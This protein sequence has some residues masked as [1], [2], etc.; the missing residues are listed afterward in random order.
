MSKIKNSLAG[1]AFV[2]LAIFLFAST[3]NAQSGT[4]KYVYTINYAMEGK[5]EFLNWVKTIVTTLQEPKELLSIAS[6]DNYFNISPARVVEFEFASNIDAAKYFDL[7]EIK[8]VV[9]QTIN[10]GIT[11]QTIVLNKR[12]DYNP[13][14]IKRRKIKYVHFLDY[15]VGNKAKYLNYVKSIV[16]TLQKPEEIKRIT[17][18]DNYFNSS[19]NR[20]IEFEFDSMEDAIKYFEMPEIKSIIEKSVDISVNH[21][22]NV[23]SLRGDYDKN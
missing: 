21:N 8:K 18:Y 19:P 17:S 7:P 20:V 16:S 22:L 23:L 6:Y 13:G 2:F 3:I 1:F 12:G 4:I 10:H 14:E 15:G 5:A 9:E 11:L